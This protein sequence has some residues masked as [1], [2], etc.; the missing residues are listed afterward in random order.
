MNKQSDFKHESFYPKAITNYDKA[1]EFLSDNFVIHFGGLDKTGRG[2][3][4][5]FK[6][7]PLEPFSRNG[8]WSRPMSN[9]V[10]ADGSINFLNNWSSVDNCYEIEPF[11]DNDKIL[12]IHAILTHMI[13][14]RADEQDLLDEPKLRYNPELQF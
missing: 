5:L 10:Y 11:L 6:L 13:E 4:K 8:F 2:Q 9:T 1:L 7:D 12:G 3:W 14:T